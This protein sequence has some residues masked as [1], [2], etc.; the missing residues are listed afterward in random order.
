[1]MGGT[2][3]GVQQQ[4]AD[5]VHRNLGCASCHGME[6]AMTSRAAGRCQGCHPQ[7]AADFT[8]GPHGIALRR[9]EPGTPTCVSCHGS[10]GV[11]AVRDSR[12]PAW[13]GQT[14]VTCGRCHQQAAEAFV[15]SV[16]GRDFVAG[17][18]M[19]MPTC[20]TCHG[21]HTATPVPR[22]Q[23]AATWWHLSH[24]GAS[25]LSTEC[26]RHGSD[27]RRAPR[28]D[29]H[30]LPWRA[31]GALCDRSHLPHR[32]FACRG[33]DVRPLPRVGADDGDAQPADPGSRRFPGELSRSRRCGR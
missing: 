28:A 20:A 31:Y 22:V 7:A 24:R 14:P 33:R 2:A 8:H 16:H 11:Y 9:G 23:V 21:A 18:G 29:V 4:L 26:A 12:S 1:M 10:H 13:T 6:H 25:G 32:C 15:T 17:K 5:S 27:A 30:R 19:T 3:S